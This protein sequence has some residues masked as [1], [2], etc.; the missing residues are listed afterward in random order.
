MTGQNRFH[1]IEDLSLYERCMLS[2]RRIS[3]PYEQTG[4]KRF[5]RVNKHLRDSRSDQF[6]MVLI[7]SRSLRRVHA[8]R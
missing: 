1:L 5:F 8:D 3:T 7:S 6:P 2:D 4:I